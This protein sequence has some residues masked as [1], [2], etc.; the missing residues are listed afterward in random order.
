MVVED[1]NDSVSYS[2]RPTGK[3]DDGLGDRNY[4]ISK[5]DECGLA[6]VG[7]GGVCGGNDSGCGGDCAVVLV[8]MLVTVMLRGAVVSKV[9]WKLQLLC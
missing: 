7:G 1:V 6:D 9:V 4:I 2:N 8:V 5:T 3:D